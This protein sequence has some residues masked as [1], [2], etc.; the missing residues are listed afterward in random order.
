MLW[1]LG[2]AAVRGIASSVPPPAAPA[3][4]SE[5]DRRFGGVA[6]IVWFAFSFPWMLAII[7]SGYDGHVSGTACVVYIL[8]NTGYLLLLIPVQAL[9]KR[10]RKLAYRRRPWAPPPDL[11]SPQA[12]RARAAELTVR[13]AQAEA[14]E[15][16]RA[17][18]V[19]D[20]L[21]VACGDCPA[22]GGEG[23][24]PAWNCAGLIPLALVQGYP[25]LYCHVSR[26]HDAVI[27]GSARLDEVAAQFS[28]NLPEGIA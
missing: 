22:T 8:A 18:R 26:M 17:R 1:L 14:G 24:M 19:A 20:L 5:Q 7:V 11:Y 16:E 2:R 23:C 9:A 6:G 13:N 15:R 3:P 27:L 25:L 4:V 10:R 12:L 28:G 21:T